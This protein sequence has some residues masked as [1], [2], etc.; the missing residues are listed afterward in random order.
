M[1][2]LMALPLTVSCFS[3]IQI[4]FTFLVP[5]HPGR[6]EQRAVKRVVCVCVSVIQ[7]RRR[8]RG[9][10]SA[11]SS[12]ARSPVTAGCASS[13]TSRSPHRCGPAWRCL[14]APWPDCTLAAAR[15]RRTPATTCSTA[16]MPTRSSYPP[17]RL[18]LRAAGDD[19]D[20]TA[21]PRCD[22]S[23][24]PCNSFRCLGHF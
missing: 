12:P 23:S 18:R 17:L 11:T 4:G 8:S 16:S 20:P 21:T 6:P 1:A 22:I 15:L 24:G 7:T 9:T 19:D 13:S 5:A 3:K 2:Q 14:A 10:S